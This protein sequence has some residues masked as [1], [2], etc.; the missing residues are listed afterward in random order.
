MRTML[1]DMSTYRV[2]QKD[3]TSLLQKKNEWVT[4][5]TEK[6]QFPSTTGL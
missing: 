6:G 1:S 2:I 3:L 5:S 4:F